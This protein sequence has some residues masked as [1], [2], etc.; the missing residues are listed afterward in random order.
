MENE[1][2]RFS[3]GP[4]STQHLQLLVFLQFFVRFFLFFVPLAGN[5]ALCQCH[6]I[7][8]V[9]ALYF[10]V[11]ANLFDLT[12]RDKMDPGQ[13]GSRTK[14]IQYK[15]KPGQWNRDNMKPGQNG[16][17]TKWIQDKMDPGQNGSG[18]TWIQDNMDPGQ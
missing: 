3:F 15:M 12:R 10:L 18:T 5:V 4:T 17:R 14:W 9:L 2:I 8:H 6:S 11:K 13:N 1:P 7:A 16:T